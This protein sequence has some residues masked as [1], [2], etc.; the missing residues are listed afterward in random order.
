MANQNPRHISSRNRTNILW[1][2]GGGAAALALALVASSAVHAIAPLGSLGGSIALSGFVALAVALPLLLVCGRQASRIETLRREVQRLGQ[3]DGLTACLNEP[4]FTALVETY[5]GSGVGRDGST[6]GTALL[7]QVDDLQ[8]INER[9][10]YSWGNEA[11]ARVAAAIRG[12]VRQ[13]DIVGRLS[14]NQFGVFLPGADEASA[15]GVADRMYQNITRA[16][17]FPTGVRYPLSI[18]AGGVVVADRTNFD[19]LLKKAAGTLAMTRGSEQ[20]WIRYSALGNWPANQPA[21]L[22]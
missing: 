12:T 14:G 11:L 15:K 19:D 20:E 17:F 18:R 21:P 3:R 10:G 16:D 8:L 6:H 13:G 7:I 9:F 22:Q 5:T 2:I 1:L 4:T